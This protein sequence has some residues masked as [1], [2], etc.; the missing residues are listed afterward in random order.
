M[1][2]ASLISAAEAIVSLGGP[3]TAL[4]ASDHDNNTNSDIPT[5]S[6]PRGHSEFHDD[7]MNSAG[8]LCFSASLNSVGSA[9]SPI[10][11]DSESEDEDNAAALCLPGSPI[12]LSS[13]FSSREP[14]IFDTPP[15][16]ATSIITNDSF[17]PEPTKEVID[18]TSDEGV[19]SNSKG[20]GRA[21]DV[22]VIDVEN[23]HSMDPQFFDDDIQMI[24]PQST[25]D[26]LNFW[27]FSSPEIAGYIDFVMDL[28]D[29][30]ELV[31]AIPWQP[32]V[33]TSTIS[34]LPTEILSMIM[35]YTLP[36]FSQPDDE[37]V[38]FHEKLTGASPLIRVCQRWRYLL[39]PKLLRSV[40][41]SECTF[42]T[43]SAHCQNCMLSA[44]KHLV[45]VPIVRSLFD[46]TATPEVTQLAEHI[47]TVS[48]SATSCE[49]RS[50]NGEDSLES[51]FVFFLPRVQ[52][53][54]I[55][56]N[57]VRNFMNGASAH[58]LNL[59]QKTLPNIRIHALPSNLS[60]AARRRLALSDYIDSDEFMDSWIIAEDIKRLEVDGDC[61]QMCTRMEMLLLEELTINRRSHGDKFIQPPTL[62]TLATL[63]S[64][65]NTEFS[66]LSKVTIRWLPKA[67]SPA[68]LAAN[69]ASH[70]N[71]T[72]VT[73]AGIP[74]LEYLDTS[75][76][77]PLFFTKKVGKCMK[78]VAF[79]YS[80]VTTKT[81]PPP[82]IKYQEFRTLIT[83]AHEMR[84]RLISD[85]IDHSRISTKI[86]LI[87]TKAR[88]K[89]HTMDVSLTTPPAYSIDLG[90][91]VVRVTEYSAKAA[92][93]YRLYIN[94]L[95]ARSTKAIMAREDKKLLS[96]YA[97]AARANSL[98]NRWDC[99]W[100]G[101][102]TT[103]KKQRTT[104]LK[105]DYDVDLDVF[106]SG[107]ASGEFMV[108]GRAKDRLLNARETE[109]RKAK[110]AE[111]ERLKKA[112]PPKKRSRKRKQDPQ[113][114]PPQLDTQP[115]VDSATKKPKVS[116][117]VVLP[118]IS[119]LLTNNTPLSFLW[120]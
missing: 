100:T 109:E 103:A 44:G 95:V 25:P 1:D 28:E 90:R 74:S 119:T 93:R 43:K 97:I 62:S 6:S 48:L 87:S 82:P 17:I 65:Y 94:S 116:S 99:S 86:S 67:E 30:T 56:S 45:S 107:A 55:P 15:Q 51:G 85:D 5:S 35:E 27:D 40:T 23:I 120:A 58:G 71:C 12:S 32:V 3:N 24:S 75:T 92:T 96:E 66:T 108:L 4:A 59:N 50:M 38:S 68:F 16:S 29:A 8:K 77:C 19:S 9:E 10:I 21:L 81:R 91:K 98:T 33:Q 88:D 61:L 53:V 36:W 2:I 64:R 22:E 113:A 31:Q 72:C 101:A 78:S 70:D 20:K 114:E 34:K 39:L 37:S 11:L 76:V 52:T 104:V 117:G 18:L 111:M 46:G 84:N 13:H 7:G 63:F 42:L 102:A 49:R 54:V 106:F 105:W 47:R 118:P 112:A 80:C 83:S 60:I 57:L 69:N 73:L 79:E 14:S 110:K 26:P 41:I 115:I 89:P